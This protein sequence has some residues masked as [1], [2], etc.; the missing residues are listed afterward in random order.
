MGYQSCA[1]PGCFEIVISSGGLDFCDECGEAGCA[2]RWALNGDPEDHPE[3]WVSDD[4]TLFNIEKYTQQLEEDQGA[5][6]LIERCACGGN[7]SRG[8]CYC[9]EVCWP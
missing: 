9:E 6:C 4:G 3:M 7:L 8:E 2:D 1:C 5:E